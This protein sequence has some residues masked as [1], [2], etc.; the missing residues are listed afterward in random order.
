M[1]LRLFTVRFGAVLVLLTLLGGG[2]LFIVQAE[3]GLEEAVIA[4][5]SL[6]R[7]VSHNSDMSLPYSVTGVVEAVD[8][9]TVYAQKSGVVE[10][11]YVKEGD[12]VT[13]GGYLAVQVDPVLSARY[14]RQVLASALSV[15]GSES[16]EVAAQSGQA[17][18][19]INQALSLNLLR[20][21][22]AADANQII[23]AE[24]QLKTSLDAMT[25]SLP[26][27][28]RFIE[29]NKSRFTVEGLRT[30]ESVIIALYGGET[31]YFAVG[32]RSSSSGEPGLVQQVANLGFASSSESLAV[33]DAVNEELSALIRSYALAEEEFLGRR[34][35]SSADPLYAAYNENRVALTELSQS[36][37]AARTG[38]VTAKD[39]GSVGG[40][41]REAG[42]ES[43]AVMSDAAAIQAALAAQ[44][45]TVTRELGAAEAAILNAELS[46]GM[47]RSP[48]AGVVSQVLVE[49]GEY[50]SV[51]Q[52][53]FTLVGT[54]DQ[55]M[56]ITVTEPF[57]TMVQVGDVFVVKG[58]EYGKVDRVVPLRRA[59]SVTA[60]IAL[61]RPVPTGTVVR[62]Q[63]L[64]TSVADTTVMINRNELFFSTT[65]PFVTTITGEKVAVSIVYDLGNTLFVIPELP[66]TDELQKAVGIR[67]K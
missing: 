67:L 48:I 15:L 44:M 50:V 46:L 22:G 57:A 66:L 32:A 54:G 1:K 23:A 29:E 61:T 26:P 42:T 63:V 18:G 55:E 25:V 3:S 34:N 40:M 49:A 17:Q 5:E 51:G 27:I 20:I 39:I 14:D 33:V 62:G 12:I 7:A 36:L 58:V 64:L 45:S 47:A 37:T 56:K 53:L 19:E 9:L 6:V 11:M 59:G 30:Y 8:S 60:Y 13:N 38:F 24:R 52:P 41:Q 2:I 4:E 43:S 28:M 31:D 21:S 35:L 10:R 16:A 65:G